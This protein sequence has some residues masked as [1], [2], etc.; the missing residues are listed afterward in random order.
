MQNVPFLRAALGFE[1]FQRGLV[2]L[3]T[4][5]I[6]PSPAS[7]II[8]TLAPL[9]GVGRRSGDELSRFDFS[10]VADNMKL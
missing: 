1:R 9:R 10:K 7:L 5:K 4:A 2:R 8:A 3:Y 6:V